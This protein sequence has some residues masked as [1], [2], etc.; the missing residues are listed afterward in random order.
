MAKTAAKKNAPTERAES[1]L[2]IRYAFD[3]A[4]NL[5]ISRLLVLADLLQDRHT[6]DNHRQ[7]ESLI[8]VV[9]G[10]HSDAPVD[11]R[12]GDH[13]VEIPE[14]QVGRMNQVKIGL[15]MAVLS[16]AVD[17]D[18]SIICLTGAAGSKRLDMM[19]IAN[20][21]RDFPWFARHRF[22][23]DREGLVSRVFASLLDI[24]LKFASEGREG[25]PLGA[26][27]VLGDP[28]ALKKYMRPLILNPFRGH[29]RKARQIENPELV[30]SLR[31]LASLDG[32]LVVDRQGVVEY[33]G[34][35]LNA[36]LTKAVDVGKG[37]GARH[38]AAAAISA[39]D[40]TVAIAISESSGTVTVF[41]QGAPVLEIPRIS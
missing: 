34:M 10:D 32:A 8:W 25:K 35:Y 28:S 22:N 16:G 6:V 11:K 12:A 33:A 27:F 9:R 5:E 17:V 36:P 24:A 7:E 31:E 41:S 23:G 18:E 37:L 39:R 13:L 2:L 3:L 14:T 29:P 20:P 26:I 38:T 15:V 40:S 21:K 30:E 1:R 19:M 4:R